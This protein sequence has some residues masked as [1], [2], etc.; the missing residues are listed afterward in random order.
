MVIINTLPNGCA[1][2]I[3]GPGEE[4][5]LAIAPKVG[6]G[7]VR[8]YKLSEKGC[9][10]VYSA[11]SNVNGF[12]TS[13][14]EFCDTKNKLK[15][16]YE[17]MGIAAQTGSV[18]AITDEFFLSE[19]GIPEEKVSYL[20]Y[21]PRDS[22]ETDDQ[23]IVEWSR[24]KSSCLLRSADSYKIMAYRVSGDFL[25]IEKLNDRNFQPEQL[26]AVKINSDGLKVACYLEP[27]SLL[28]RGECV[29]AFLGNAQVL[30]DCEHSDDSSL[31]SQSPATIL[32]YKLEGAFSKV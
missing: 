17:D 25:D 24:D 26:I 30:V 12:R 20:I 11:N 2:A 27:M 15:V 16:S 13:R 10:Y 8:I 19:S 28:G 32:K 4:P 23:V 1:D 22:L 5:Y 7:S 14:I 6:G 31:G 29:K 21:I 3:L 18:I 9:E